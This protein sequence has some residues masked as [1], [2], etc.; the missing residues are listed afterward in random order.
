[1]IARIP[2]PTEPATLESISAAN[3]G[4]K[5]ELEADGSITM[6]PTGTISGARD[7]ALSILLNE[8]KRQRG[9]QLFGSST[10][11]TT[12]RA[13]ALI[14]KLQRYRAYGAVFVLL[15]DPY[16][17]TTWSDGAA[18]PGFPTD[19]TSVFDAGTV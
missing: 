11:F 2:P 8:W 7:M 6:S 10:G 3:S 5:V 1:M 14:A 17:R 4:W 9:G 16:N 19:Y 15:I 12:D 18:P 13:W